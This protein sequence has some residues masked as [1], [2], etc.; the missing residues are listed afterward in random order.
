VDGAEFPVV[1]IPAGYFVMTCVVEG[2]PCMGIRVSQL[3][4]S[5]QARLNIAAC[6]SG[7][8]DKKVAQPWLDLLDVEARPTIR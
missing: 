5:P 3:T 4:K 6:V 8:H 7:D 2:A 1:V